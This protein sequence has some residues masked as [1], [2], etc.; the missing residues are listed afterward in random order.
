MVA[1]EQAVV[2]ERGHGDADLSQVIQVLQDR[3]LGRE[4]ER[5]SCRE[6]SALGGR[7]GSGEQGKGAPGWV[8]HKNGKSKLGSPLGDGWE[9]LII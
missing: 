4:E 1:E 7:T 5:R 8:S 2:A 3:G 6:A 9:E